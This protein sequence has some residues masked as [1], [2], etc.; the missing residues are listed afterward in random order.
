MKRGLHLAGGQGETYRCGFR[1]T[2]PRGV[3]FASRRRSRTEPALRLLQGPT[4]PLP[5]AAHTPP[6]RSSTVS[7]GEMNQFADLN[8]IVS[9]TSD[10]RSKTENRKSK[11]N[12]WPD[13]PIL[14]VSL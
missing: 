9:R 1:I 10:P 13:D 2:A 6:L 4:C 5:R 14:M 12:R 8:N 7:S 11:M 3:H